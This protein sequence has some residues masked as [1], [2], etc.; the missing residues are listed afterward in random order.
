MEPLEDRRLLSGLVGPVEPVNPVVVVVRTSFV[1][2]LTAGV[3]PGTPIDGPAPL[4]VVR[5]W[6]HPDSP[7]AGGPFGGQGSAGY[8]PG[9]GWSPSD[10]PAESLGLPRSF[11]YGT[12][13]GAG[14]STPWSSA[15]TLSEAFSA[16]PWSGGWGG[17]AGMDR[18]WL[19]GA[20][21][22]HGWM[23]IAESAFSPWSEPGQS[24]Q[25]GGPSYRGE[26]PSQAQEQQAAMLSQGA[27]AAWQ[28]PHD[29]A[30]PM[31]ASVAAIA[32]GGPPRDPLP[33]LASPTR[34]A[35]APSAAAAAA[36]ALPPTPSAAAAASLSKENAPR[37]SL[38]VVEALARGGMLELST[39]LQPGLLLG[40]VVSGLLPGG[41]LPAQPAP[42]A[43]HGHGRAADPGQAAAQMEGLTADAAAAA[44]ELAAP[45]GAGPIAEALP[46][47]GRSLRAAI[48]RL[49][50]GFNDV[51]VAPAGADPAAEARGG[52]VSVGILGLLAMTLAARHRLRSR[53]PA[54]SARRREGREG[55]QALELPELP[56]SWS[57]R[58]T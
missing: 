54:A 8:G 58:L 31:L 46:A 9:S 11:A 36:Q 12:S 15:P 51:D 19:K 10:R 50:D 26:A 49:L 7:D 21:P 17:G 1:G 33:P 38:G 35:D 16:R 43:G 34:P 28:R 24:T 41:S 56:G 25:G 53:R 13:L 14:A 32:L 30:G 6:S 55:D 52:P 22:A 4:V 48:E 40:N 20:E 18:P 29:G 27:E 5:G 47:D 37:A 57:T 39:G 2:P 44:G 23:S 3:A 45:E 42:V